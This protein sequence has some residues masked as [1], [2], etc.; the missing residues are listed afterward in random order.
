MEHGRHNRNPGIC[1]SPNCLDSNLVDR[2][3]GIELLHPKPHILCKQHW[4]EKLSTEYNF[5]NFRECEHNGVYIPNPKK[6]Y[7]IPWKYSYKTNKFNFRSIDFHEN[8]E[9]VVLGC[10]HTFG[11]GIPVDFIWPTFVSD[12]TGIK[13][14]VNLSVV[15]SSISLQVRLLATYINRYSAPKIILCNFPDFNRYESIDNFGRIKMGSSNDAN[16][17]DF[18]KNELSSYM[19]NL[20]AV[21]FLES[22]CKTNNIKLAW[23]SWSGD[24]TIFEKLSFSEEFLRNNFK[25]YI[26]FKDYDIWDPDRNKLLHKKGTNE[27]TYTG[28]PKEIPCC[29]ELSDQTKEFFYIGYDRYK[30]EKKFQFKEIDE[31]FFNENLSFDTKLSL[32]KQAHLGSHAHWHWAKNLVDNI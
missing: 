3:N 7:N 20:Q 28:N 4:F 2:Y 22:I 13:D 9:I 14:V 26:T 17:E 12:L 18:S 10:S 32:I 21:N 31:K 29:K 16:Y 11:V 8:T 19:E 15:G 24:I 27:I 5:L 1:K 6:E 23:Q 30:V 25:N